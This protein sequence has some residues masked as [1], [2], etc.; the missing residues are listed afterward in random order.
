M[1]NPF[2]QKIGILILLTIKR[3]FFMLLLRIQCSFNLLI[4]YFFLYSPHLYVWQCVEI[5]SRNKLFVT[6]KSERVKV[7]FGVLEKSV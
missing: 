4:F 7:N 2:N 6:S 5:V 1:I 3:G